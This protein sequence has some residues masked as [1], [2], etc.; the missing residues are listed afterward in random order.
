MREKVEEAVDPVCGDAVEQSSYLAEHLGAHFLFCSEQ[1]K[2]RFLS[3]PGLFV[4]CP[5]EKAPRQEGQ[6]II[7]QRCMRLAFP[8]D[9][10]KAE[11]IQDI[12]Q[13]L[14]GVKSSAVGSDHIDISYDL[15]L[16]SAEEIEEKIIACGEEL[17][18]RL[19]DR[20]ERVFIH[21]EEQ[22]EISSIE[23]HYQNKAD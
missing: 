3:H 16:I 6:E 7:K 4:G 2:E 10:G 18:H 11:K 21:A 22:N 19:R 5:G 12:L 14:L 20:L 8:L 9:S 23:V 1:C 17:G 15:L 13:D